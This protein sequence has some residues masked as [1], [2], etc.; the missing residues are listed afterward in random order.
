MRPLLTSRRLSQAVAGTLAAVLLAGCS[1]SVAGT[2]STSASSS[3]AA[4]TVSGTTVEDV[5]DGNVEVETGGTSY[6]EGDATAGEAPAGG[7]MG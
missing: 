1:A 7:P 3:S 5:L 4:V 2:S 6:D